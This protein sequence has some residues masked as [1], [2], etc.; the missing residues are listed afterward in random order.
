MSTINVNSATALT[1]A[2][3]AANGGDAILLAPGNYGKLTSSHKFASEVT[4]KS[5]DMANPAV[6][7]GLALNGA[8]NLTFDGV[9]FDYTAITNPND[10]TTPFTA[11]KS[12]HIT[13][14]NSV[15]DG[16]LVEGS[17][18]SRDGYGTGYGLR[19]VDCTHLTVA[20]CRF[21]DFWKTAMFLRVDDLVVVRNEISRSREDSLNFIQVNRV[22]IEQNHIHTPLVFGSGHP[23]LIQFWTTNTT[24]PST[25]ITIRGN[26]LN[27]GAGSMTQSLFMGNEMASSAGEA[28]YYRN[29]LVE[30]NV[31]HNAHLHG[32]TVGASVGVIV[33]YN[34]ILHNMD[35][36]SGDNVWIPRINNSS[37]SQDVVVEKNVVPDVWGIVPADLGVIYGNPSHE[38]SV[39]NLFVNGLAGKT[40]TLADLRAVSGGLIE[41]LGVGAAMTRGEATPVPDPTPIPPPDPDPDPVPD[42]DPDP[43]PPPPSGDVAIHLYDAVT[44]TFVRVIEDGDNIDPAL[45]IGKHINIVALPTVPV[46]KVVFNLDDGAKV[47]I[48]SVAPYALWGDSDGNFNSGSLA[49]GTHTLKVT[50]KA[51]DGSNVFTTTV[52]FHVADA[53]V[54]PAPDPDPVPDPEPEPEPNMAPVAKDMSYTTMQRTT[55]TVSASDGVL[56]GTTDANMDDLSARMLAG[57]RYGKLLFKTNGSFSYTPRGKFKG[58]DSFTFRAYDGEVES[59]LATATITVT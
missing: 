53:P 12:H 3:A 15:F 17:G 8:E 29:V 44:D 36:A 40:A 20:D 43:V 35:T 52:E 48:E 19:A 34:T 1:S 58:V 50:G 49:A 45:I 25:D 10:S 41:Q 11:T 22:L 31:I 59:N 28:M 21:Y 24:A 7:S 14:R 38:R 55:L 6:F 2:L 57:P 16:D 56:S 51:A 26:F 42:P 46:A 39:E 32:I 27:S 9:K 4:I 23:D 13:F 47:Q 37:L 18:T 54:E 33:R 5:A 30:H